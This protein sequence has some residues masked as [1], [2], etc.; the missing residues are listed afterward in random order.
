MAEN[1]TR[2]FAGVRRS[3]RR[4]EGGRTRDRSM[5]KVREENACPS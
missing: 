5:E 1:G 3:A 4:E 2:L